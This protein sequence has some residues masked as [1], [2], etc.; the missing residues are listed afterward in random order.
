MSNT[1]IYANS[2]IQIVF[3]L[4]FS[5][6]VFVFAVEYAYCNIMKKTP[7]LLPR[8]ASV[9]LSVVTALINI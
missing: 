2:K 9:C 7:R 3:L 8:C 5:A 6:S 1:T 4:I